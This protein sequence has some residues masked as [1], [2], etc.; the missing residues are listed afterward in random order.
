[1]TL[2]LRPAR[3]DEAD[4]LSRLALASK[5]HWGYDAAFLAACRDALRV[6]AGDIA[7]FPHVVAEREGTVVGFSSLCPGP[8]GWHLDKLFVSPTCTRQGVGVRLWQHT[9]A[10][11]RAADAP[12]LLIVSDLHAEGFY[13][14][15]GAERVGET[16]SEASPD[17][18]LPLMRYGL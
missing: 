16:P 5:A 9:L 1:M 13:R 6:T 7:R 17:R 15:M 14:A 4:A 11:A 12:F 3:E 10:E 2:T 8:E 18:R